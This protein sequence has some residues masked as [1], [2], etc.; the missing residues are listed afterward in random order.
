MK[1]NTV[2]EEEKRREGTRDGWARNCTRVKST[3]E[4]RQEWDSNAARYDSRCLDINGG[5]EAYL[6]ACN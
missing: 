4:R 6:R 1:M 5:L 3:D 2:V